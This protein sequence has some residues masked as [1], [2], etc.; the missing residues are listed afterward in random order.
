MTI[1][2]ILLIIYVTA[3]VGFIVILSGLTLWEFSRKIFYAIYYHNH[4][5]KLKTQVKCK[6][7]DA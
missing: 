3:T 2:W 7:E 5:R 6:E 1:V 4:V